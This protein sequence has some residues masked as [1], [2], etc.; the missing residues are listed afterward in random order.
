MIHE[1]KKNP[2]SA[3]MYLDILH[4][5]TGILIV[6]CAVL[7]FLDPDNN[8]FLF[9]VIFWLAAFL[10]A[11]SGRHQLSECGRDRKKKAG[12]VCRLTAAA[13]LL[14]IGVVSAVS[15]WR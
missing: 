8:S 5:V 10:N 9:P 12:A 15:I 6:L 13:G 3:A 4:I 11:A 7:A 14:L 2:R 1:K